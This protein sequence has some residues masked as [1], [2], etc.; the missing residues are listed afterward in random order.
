MIISQFTISVYVEQPFINLFLF[1]VF[2]TILILAFHFWFLF[3]AKLKIQIK[4][5]GQQW[6]TLPF[7]LWPLE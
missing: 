7:A 4:G 5:K 2:L 3:L 1:Y 6:S